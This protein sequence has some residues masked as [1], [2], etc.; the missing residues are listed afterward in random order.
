M[1]FSSGKGVLVVRRPGQLK[2]LPRA[3]NVPRMGR[4]GQALDKRE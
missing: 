1:S 4:S 2:C 3:R